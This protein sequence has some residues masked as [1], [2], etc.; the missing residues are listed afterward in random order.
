[1]LDVQEVAGSSPVV[2]TK[3]LADMA[4]EAGLQDFFTSPTVQDGK[5]TRAKNPVRL[6][7]ARRTG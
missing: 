2:S 3:S 4:V 1:M 5:T 7:E 6:H